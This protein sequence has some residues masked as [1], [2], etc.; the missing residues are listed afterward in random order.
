MMIGGGRVVALATAN[1]RATKSAWG[2]MVVG[3]GRTGV[4]ETDPLLISGSGDTKNR[5]YF[6]GVR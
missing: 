2:T 5:V 3:E 1:R 6:S 4:S